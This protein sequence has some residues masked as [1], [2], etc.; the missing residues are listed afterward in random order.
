MEALFRD[1]P[2]AV[3]TVTEDLAIGA[4]SLTVNY[5]LKG[6]GVQVDFSKISKAI[7][8]GITGAIATTGTMA[9]VYFQLPP[10]AQTHFPG[11]VYSVLPWV[12][13]AIGFAVG[14]CGVYLAP[15]NKG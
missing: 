9:A 7:A 4:I 15:P 12:N 5:L 8:G 14:F 13:E 6:T 10:E 2:S 3:H 11:F 1:P